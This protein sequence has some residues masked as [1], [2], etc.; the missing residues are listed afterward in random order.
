MNHLASTALAAGFVVV[1]ATAAAAQPD[2]VPLRFN[3][4]GQGVCPSNYVIQGNVCVHLYP[5]R[6]ARHGYGGGGYHGHD[7]YG[8]R[9]PSPPPFGRFVQPRWSPYGGSP[10]CPSGYDYDIRGN[11]CVYLY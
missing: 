10:R 11:V 7:S 6:D 4:Y 1:T 3:A 5:T 8:Y 9:R 2:V